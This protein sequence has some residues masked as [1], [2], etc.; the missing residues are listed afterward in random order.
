MNTTNNY[1]GTNFVKRLGLWQARCRMYKEDH[2][3]GYFRN[4]IAAA[5][6]YNKKASELSDF[7][8]LN[9]LNFST[10][11]L[12]NM[13]ITE[14]ATPPVAEFQSGVKGIRWNC[15]KKKWEVVIGRK[16]FGSYKEMSVAKEILQR[17]T[18]NV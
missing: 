7:T 3:L 8:L 13:L 18:W 1:K 4:E 16:Y 10:E 6:A 14:R 17:S 2:F 9:K 12:E 5:Y 11:E 15:G